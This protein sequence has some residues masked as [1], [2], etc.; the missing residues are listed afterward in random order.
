MVERN[1]TD[2]KLDAD[3]V[4]WLSEEGDDLRE[5]IIE[6]KVPRRTVNLVSPPSKYLLPEEIKGNSSD[7]TRA[8]EGL[9]SYLSELLGTSTNLLRSA[10]AVVVRANREQLRQIIRHPLVRSVH[11]NRRLKPRGV[12]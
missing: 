7:R 9:Q 6:A 5:L 3:L 11:S 12:V 2:Q 8:L 10:G 1:T 4:T